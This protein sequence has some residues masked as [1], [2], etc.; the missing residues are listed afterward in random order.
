MTFE[1]K[2]ILRCNQNVLESTHLE[3]EIEHKFCIF[4][5][6][7]QEIYYRLYLAQRVTRNMDSNYELIEGRKNGSLMFCSRIWL[8]NI[9]SI[10]RDHSSQ[11]QILG[12]KYANG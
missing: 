7:N 4:F 5:N 1:R 10:S 3:L 9:F 2:A 8:G 11:N 12:K 6:E